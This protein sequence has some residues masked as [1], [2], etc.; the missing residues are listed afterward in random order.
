[1]DRYDVKMPPTWGLCV[2]DN[3][4]HHVLRMAEA[5]FFSEEAIEPIKATTC[6]KI[7]R[8][9]VSLF[10]HH[11]IKEYLQWFPGKKNNV[12]DA[13]SWDFNLLDISS[14]LGKRRYLP[15]E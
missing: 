12:T 9:H 5:D 7:A 1:M 13:L 8:K 6:L 3:G 15:W 14:H 2:I 10:I 11:N 4:Q